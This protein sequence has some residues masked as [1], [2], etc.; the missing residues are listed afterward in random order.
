MKIS[1]IIDTY[2]GIHMLVNNA[3]GQFVCNAEGRIYDIRIMY[4]YYFI[5]VLL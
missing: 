2:G 1:H 3:G 5:Y 4:F